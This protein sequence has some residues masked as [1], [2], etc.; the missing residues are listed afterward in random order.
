MKAEMIAWMLQA[1]TAWSPVDRP[2]YLPA[3]Q[4][5]AEEARVRYEQIATAI[6]DAAFDPAEAP[7]IP[8]KRGRIFTATAMMSLFFFESGYRKDIDLGIGKESRG[9]FGRSWC[10]GQHNLGKR[11]VPDPEHEGKYIEDSASRTPEGWSGRDLVQDRAKC[12]R[13]TLHAMRVSFGSCGGSPLEERLTTYA[14]GICRVSSTATEEQRARD[15]KRLEDGRKKSA[16][17]LRKARMWM[18]S[19]PVSFTDTDVMAPPAPTVLPVADEGQP[20][21]VSFLGVRLPVYTRQRDQRWCLFSTRQ[22]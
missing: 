8:G 19:H 20:A 16:A 4:E 10:M 2:H 22:Y 15:E 14:T 6:V 17:R 18:Q 9:D 13:A 1:M 7:L 11:M 12:A 3:A 5:T 21:E